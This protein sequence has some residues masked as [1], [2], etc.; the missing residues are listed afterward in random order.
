[1]V[2]CTC[3]EWAIDCLNNRAASTSNSR[4]S[5]SPEPSSSHFSKSAAQP[6]S[7][8]ISA[9]AAWKRRFTASSFAPPPPPPP[10]LPPPSSCPSLLRGR[11]PLLLP[12]RLPRFDDASAAGLNSQSTNSVASISP[13]PSPIGNR[14][15]N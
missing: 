7:P 5:N 11:P 13:E 4:L 6:S 9:L 2:V 15:R 1:V 12:P 10:P 3:M 8:D 14:A